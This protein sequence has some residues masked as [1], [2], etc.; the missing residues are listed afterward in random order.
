[1]RNVLTVL[2]VLCALAPVQSG[3][4]EKSAKAIAPFLDEQA[5]AV[6]RVD[7][8]GADVDAVLQK[9]VGFGFPLGEMERKQVKHWRSELGKAG[10]KD[11][12]IVWSLADRLGVPFAVI[13]ADGEEAARALAGVI[14]GSLPVDSEAAGTSVLIGS[15]EAVTRLRDV[16][17]A[18]F[19]ALPKAFAAAGEGTFQAV[20]IPPST[21]RRAVT[22]IIPKLPKEL[23]DVPVSVVDRGIVWIAASVNIAPKMSIRYVVQSRDKTAAKDL[24]DLAGRFV[25]TLMT[26]TDA[27]EMLPDWLKVYPQLA[28]KAQ[29]DRVVLDLD[30]QVISRLVVP[31]LEKIK[32]SAARTQSINNLKQIGLA[33]HGYVDTFKSRSLPAY[34]SFDK[35]GKPLLS[36]RVHLL[37]YVD[38]AELYK[39]FH[40]DE[41]WDS[42]HNKK[43]I[44]RMPGTYRSPLSKAGAGKTTY[45][46]PLGKQALF[47]GKK[48]LL[49]PREVPDGTSNT[50]IVVECNDDNAVI[51]TKPADYNVDVENLL[52]GLLRPGA[53]GFPVGMA[54]GSVRL[55]SNRVTLGT[56]R[57]AFTRNGGEV[58][59]N[60]W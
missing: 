49:F 27:K 6:V 36:W 14:R 47:G 43:L 39:Q 15:K 25:Q 57:A 53:R 22:E 23:G 28:P 19:P 8:A 33:M 9:L 4:P 54:D 58:L 48:G 2:A 56:L 5:V 17:A 10:A 21:L 41:P 18:S 55:I 46:V 42:E 35:D 38:G 13:P 44:A 52:K 20:V 45:L 26:S 12:F 11:A 40:L 31:G 1:M 29:G 37:P 32:E 60:D 7:V 3:E 24:A 30:D 16:K 59:G 51:W 50:I 34:A